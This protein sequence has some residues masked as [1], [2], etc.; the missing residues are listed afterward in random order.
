MGTNKLRKTAGP[1]TALFSDQNRKLVNGSLIIKINSEQ[2]ILRVDLI[3]FVPNCADNG[4][5]C[6]HARGK[7]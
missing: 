3:S 7:V 5:V 1:Q 2:N 6:T 4:F